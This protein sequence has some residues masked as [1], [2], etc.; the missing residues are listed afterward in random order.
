MAID[1]CRIHGFICM[2]DECVSVLAQFKFINKLV[3]THH[4]NPRR[5]C[6]SALRKT[7]FGRRKRTMSECVPASQKTAEGTTSPFH[8]MNMYLPTESETPVER[9]RTISSTRRRSSSSVT[10]RSDRTYVCLPDRSQCPSGRGFPIPAPA[11]KF[12]QQP[13]TW[14]DGSLPCPRG[15]WPG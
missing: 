4:F 12:E 7:T 14:S 5:L 8:Q 11:L 9:N 3:T 2:V 6:C 1:A 13:H 15:Y 10:S